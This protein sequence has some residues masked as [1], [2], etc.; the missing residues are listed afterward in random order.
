MSNSPWAFAD[1]D[2]ELELANRKAEEEEIIEI[3]VNAD[4]LQ[5]IPHAARVKLAMTLF[6]FFFDKTID[7]S[8]ATLLITLSMFCTHRMYRKDREKFVDGI[9]TWMRTSPG[10]DTEE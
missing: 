2:A 6:Q 4:G 10:W 8:L 7:S 5:D 3:T 9:A 1:L